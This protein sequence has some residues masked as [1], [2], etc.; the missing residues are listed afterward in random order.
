MKKFLLVFIGVFIVAVLLFSAIN[1]E[2]ALS[3]VK[4]APENMGSLNPFSPITFYFNRV[5]KNGE[6]SFVITP[7]TEVS[8]LPGANSSIQIIPKTTF[9]PS[10]EYRILAKTVP[11]YTLTLSSEQIESNTP[12]WNELF[13]AAEQQYIA[14]RGSQDDALIKIRAAVPIQQ[15]GFSV[16]YSYKNNTY[17]VTLLPPYETNKQAFLSWIRQQGVTDTGTLRIE[18][19]NR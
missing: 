16:N 10:A 15:S 12:G 2:P 5:P 14:T 3:V 8:F 7:P 13:N 11:P 1:R 6:V 19:F 4:T 17:S 18:Y 9:A